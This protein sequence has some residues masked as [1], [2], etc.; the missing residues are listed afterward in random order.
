MNEP[1]AFWKA[2][3]T[4]CEHPFDLPV[5]LGWW[6]P[7]YLARECRSSRNRITTRRAEL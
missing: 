3:G 5:V 6:S 4:S 1:L 7:E 2:R